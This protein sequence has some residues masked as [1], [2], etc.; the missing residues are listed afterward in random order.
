[1]LEIITV[2]IQKETP[3]LGWPSTY[4]VT[5]RALYSSLSAL[6]MRNLTDPTAPSLLVLPGFIII[7][8]LKYIMRF[9][10]LFFNTNTADRNHIK[11]LKQLF[12]RV[13]LLEIRNKSS[14][15]KIINSF[16]KN[17]Y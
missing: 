4:A 7:P 13:K 11:K 9:H 15:S 2:Y 6:F 16:L 1:M 17:I 14:R 12:K 8:G 3:L 10:A 5:T